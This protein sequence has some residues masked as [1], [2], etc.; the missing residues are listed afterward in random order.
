MFFL[1]RKK[2]IEP[3][4]TT[5]IAAMITATKTSCC[6]VIENGNEEFPTPVAVFPGGGA[7]GRLVVLVCIPD[8]EA[9]DCPVLDEELV[10]EAEAVVEAV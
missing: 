8:A 9:V 10:E 7:W 6:W 5:I 3:T 4:E 2:S 1:L